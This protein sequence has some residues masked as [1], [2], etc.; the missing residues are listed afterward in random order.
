MSALQPSR[1]PIILDCDPGHDD[2]I[3]LLLAAASP[4]I[5]LRLVSVVAGNQTLERTLQN[6]LAVISAS[7]RRDYRSRRAWEGLW[8]ASKSWPVTSMG[9]RDW[10]GRRYRRSRSSRN[11][12]T[13]S[14]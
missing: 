3:A 4:A 2:A 1:T 10:M 6:A 8:C 14:N 5:D 12:A 7:G 13:P 9:S 11:R